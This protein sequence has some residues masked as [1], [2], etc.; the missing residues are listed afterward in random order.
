MEKIEEIYRKCFLLSLVLHFLFFGATLFLTKIPFLEPKTKIIWTT[1][2]KGV[3]PLPDTKIKEAKTLPETTIKEQKEARKEAIKKKTKKPL[4]TPKQKAKAKPK[5]KKK[6]EVEKALAALDKKIEAEAAQVKES[7]EGYEFGTG[8]QSNRIPLSDP[9]YIVYQT[10]VR[11]KIMGEW[12]LPLSYLEVENPPHATL[13]VRVNKTGEIIAS[14]WKSKSDNT[15][16]DTSC[17]R[18]IQRSS[19]LP[20]PP[21]RLEWEV[22]REGFEVEFDSTLKESLL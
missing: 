3:S 12:I 5:P 14:Y 18:A 11:H 17:L 10:K 15:A 7:G 6:T 22:L 9:E 21:Q 1:L 16:F 13:I 19:P 4:V 2:P 8:T 20:I